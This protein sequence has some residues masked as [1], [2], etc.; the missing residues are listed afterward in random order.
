MT[1]SP[2]RGR[3]STTCPSRRTSTHV[4]AL[5]QGPVGAAAR[6]PQRHIVSTCSAAFTHVF[7]EPVGDVDPRSRRHRRPRRPRP[8][9]VEVL[10][11]RVR[12]RMSAEL[13]EGAGDEVGRRHLLLHPSRRQRR[14]APRSSIS[15]LPLSAFQSCNRSGSVA[16][17]TW[18]PSS[19]STLT[20]GKSPVARPAAVDVPGVAVAGR[21]EAVGLRQVDG[22]RCTSSTSERTANRFKDVVELG[23]PADVGGGVPEPV[24]SRGHRAPAGRPTPPAGRMP[25]SVAGSRI[26]R[27]RR[28]AG[29]GRAARRTAGRRARPCTDS[30]AYDPWA[31]RALCSP[32]PHRQ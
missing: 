31:A 29:S 4:R 17:A 9:R 30:T 14:R 24:G 22:H 2:G 28:S 12:R 18:L 3:P 10:V 26:G 8:D 15:R 32:A 11:D 5:G 6:R 19:S 21:P 25:C 23:E 1:T 13:V 16:N 20:R 27:S 7:L